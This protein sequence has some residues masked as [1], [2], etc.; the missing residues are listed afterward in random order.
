MEP[1]IVS[2][3]Q[4]LPNKHASLSPMSK[5]SLVRTMVMNIGS[6]FEHPKKNIR[7]E[8]RGGIRF[9]EVI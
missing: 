8:M 5:F 9:S 6:A 2:L 4:R 7:D 1:F 3:V